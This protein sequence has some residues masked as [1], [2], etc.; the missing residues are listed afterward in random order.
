[1]ATKIWQVF[2]SL[3]FKNSV[4]LKYPSENVFKVGSATIHTDFLFYLKTALFEIHQE[5]DQ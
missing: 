1:M 5:L 3:F 4:G 2:L